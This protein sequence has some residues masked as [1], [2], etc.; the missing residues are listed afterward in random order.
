MWVIK[1]R[2]G[3]FHQRKRMVTPDLQKAKTYTTEK[4]AK[5]AVHGSTYAGDMSKDKGGHIIKHCRLQ[6]W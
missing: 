3:T 2:D 1:Y 4:A 6:E 5:A